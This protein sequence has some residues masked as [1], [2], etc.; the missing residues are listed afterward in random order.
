MTLYVSYQCAHTILFITECVNNLS[1]V[2][3]LDGQENQKQDR[4][5]SQ[6]SG[7]HTKE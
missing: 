7:M 5:D 1:V 4:S 2:Q 3:V 6:E